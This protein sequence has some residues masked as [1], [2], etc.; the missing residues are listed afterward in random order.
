MKRVIKYGTEQK[1]NP[2]YVFKCH[3]GCEFEADSKDYRCESSPKNERY[4]ISKC[5]ESFCGR[6]VYYDL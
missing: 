5:P 1:V 4:A 6:D 3:C 2:V